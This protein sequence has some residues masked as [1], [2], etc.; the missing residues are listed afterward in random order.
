MELNADICKD[1]I[2]I[3]Y[4][5]RSTHNYNLSPVVINSKDLPILNSVKILGFTGNLSKV[6]IERTITS[7]SVQRK[8]I[9]AFILLYS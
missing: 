1:M 2:M 4:F 5:K 8:P 7:S 3:M 9:S 6:E